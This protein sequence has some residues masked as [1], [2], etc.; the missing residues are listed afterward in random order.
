MAEQDRRCRRELRQ[1]PGVTGKAATNAR[2]EREAV[3]GI[4]NSAVQ[5]LGQ[6]FG[7]EPLMDDFP[8]RYLPR[9]GYR[10]RPIQ[11]HG[12]VALGAIVRR[13]GA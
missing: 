11:G 13:G 10:V 12:A 8:G 4:A 9:H 2:R 5:Q 3:L 7:A 6:W 1:F